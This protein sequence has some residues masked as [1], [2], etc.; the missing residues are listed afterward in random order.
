MRKYILYI[1][2]ISLMMS[3]FFISG[4]FFANSGLVS[5]NGK[6]VDTEKS[7]EIL[8]ELDKLPMI[9]IDPYDLTFYSSGELVDFDKETL[10]FNSDFSGEEVFFYTANLSKLKQG[11]EAKIYYNYLQKGGRNIF[12]IKKILQIEDV[13]DFDTCKEYGG[14]VYYY[15]FPR[16]C[17]LGQVTFT[18]TLDEL[19]E[20]CM[21]LDGIWIDDF[22]ECERISSN[23]C[24]FLGGE[25][26][27]C[28]SA[29]RND[30]SA[31]FCIEV[32]VQVC[33]FN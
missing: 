2:L 1:I 28:E 8:V 19:K 18:K 13:V 20:K 32:C 12:K 4:L 22:N 3:S 24:Y 27:S 5:F 21:S 17:V 23:D 33:K 10:T 14:I 11:D 15:E 31:E 7:I 30:P 9:S 29:C 6:G 26:F 16:K 25:F